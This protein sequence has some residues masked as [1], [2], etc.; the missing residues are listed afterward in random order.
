MEAIH[1][2]HLL[3]VDNHDSFVYNLV[4]MIEENGHCTYDIVRNE[5]IA[6]EQSIGYKGIL[7]SPGPGLP[8]EAGMLCRL[9]EETYRDT[10]IL[11]ICLGHQAI[12]EV[13]GGRLT[14]L[15]H[16]LHGHTSPL[17]ITEPDELLF[18]GIE[19]GST[20]GHYHS[21]I[22][23]QEDCPEELLTTAVDDKGQI[24]AFRHRRYP[25]RSVQFHP[26]SIM[27]TAGKNMIDNWISSL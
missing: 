16:P 15:E 26:E 20:I 17:F 3:I 27:T 21:W 12:A 24:M 8:C 2:K 7:L 13:F 19:D 10:P 5:C 25:V 11:G 22:V 1:P 6:L 9:I 23:R 4:Q 18:R 14:R